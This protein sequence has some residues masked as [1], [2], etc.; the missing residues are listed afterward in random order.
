MLYQKPNR[1]LW[2]SHMKKIHTEGIKIA[3]KYV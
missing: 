3:L 1:K 2:K